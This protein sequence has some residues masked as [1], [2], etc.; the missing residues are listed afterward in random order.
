[1]NIINYYYMPRNKMQSMKVLVTGSTSIHGWPIYRLLRRLLP[2]SAVCAICPPGTSLPVDGNVFS[3]CLTDAP[4]LAGIRRTFSPTHI[5]HAGGICDLD[6][7]EEDPARAR[8]INVLGT[9]SVIEIFGGSCCC[10]YL[11]V[12]LVFSGNN[13]PCDGYAENHATDPVSVVGKTFIEAENAFMQAPSWSI[14]RLGLPMGSSV[15][16]RKG[17]V[18][19]I[20]GRLRR[21]LPMS[22]F[23]D[24]LRSCIDCYDMASAVTDMLMREAH[25]LYHL[26][27]PRA[28]SLYDIGLAILLRGGHNP[29][30]L[31]RWSRKDDIHGPPRI[32][33]VHLNSEKAEKF[34]G[35]KIP[36]WNI[37]DGGFWYQKATGLMFE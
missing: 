34:L 20:E 22:L 12:D 11:S 35:R 2:Q 31:K 19:F 16:G 5:I 29:E 33:N 26:G 21:N 10:M 4:A 15:D 7:C 37:G 17:G 9:Q 23:H 24:E 1:L 8:A 30:H 14:I 13:P 3:L 32:G 25:G 36:A 6:A 27:G 18:D 28:V